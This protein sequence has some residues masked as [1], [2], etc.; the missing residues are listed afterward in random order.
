MDVDQELRRDAIKPRLIFSL[1]M[2]LSQR[3]ITRYELPYVMHDTAVVITSV[4]LR[5]RD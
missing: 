2:N 5:S 3:R 1:A 4:I